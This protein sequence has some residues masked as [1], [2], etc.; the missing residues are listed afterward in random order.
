[1][2]RHGPPRPFYLSEHLDRTRPNDSDEPTDQKASTKSRC[3][4]VDLAHRAPIARSLVMSGRPGDSVRHCPPP[5]DS[6]NVLTRQ[7]R[8]AHLHERPRIASGCS[9]RE[10]WSRV[11]HE[12]LGTARHPP[13]FDGRGMRPS[14]L[15]MGPG[16]IRWHQL[17]LPVGEFKSPLRHDLS[18][19]RHAHG[20]CRVSWFSS[21]VMSGNTLGVARRG[22]DRPPTPDTTDGLFGLVTG[23][24][25][26]QECRLA[27]GL[28]I[29]AGRCRD[30]P[31][32]PCRPD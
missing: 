27:N 26:S 19:A 21:H 24:W 20:V 23:L 10:R 12:C 1:M 16:A 30:P 6:P 8:P 28:L 13:R 25:R 3:S 9:I 5:S 18:H 17:P 4:G 15:V 2:G 22:C 11:G 32:V 29:R 31:A 7:M 14:T